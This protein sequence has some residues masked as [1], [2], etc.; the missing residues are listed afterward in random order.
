MFTM[1]NSN[2]LTYYLSLN[3]TH[4]FNALL[5]NEIIHTVGA[6]FVECIGSP[7]PKR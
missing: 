7:F 1:I 6:F 5:G 4:H 2:V 3:D